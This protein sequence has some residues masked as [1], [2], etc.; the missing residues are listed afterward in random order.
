[1]TE[2]FPGKKDKKKNK[3]KKNTTTTKF[4]CHL[5]LSC[6]PFIKCS[7]KAKKSILGLFFAFYLL[8]PKFVLASGSSSSKSEN[9]ADQSEDGFMSTK[10]C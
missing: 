10:K 2:D 5:S 3:N 9:K 7:K 1:M 8:V 4:I 6:L